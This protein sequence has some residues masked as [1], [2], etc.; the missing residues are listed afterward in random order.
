MFI[1]L[2]CYSESLHVASIFNMD[3]VGKMPLQQ[4]EAELGVALIG[5]QKNIMNSIQPLRVQL[6]VSR[7]S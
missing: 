6:S 7:E 4:L 5:Q 1:K 3:D 2:S